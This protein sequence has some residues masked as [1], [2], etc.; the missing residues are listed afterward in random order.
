[1]RNTGCIS[2][3]AGPAERRGARSFKRLLAP[4]LA[5]VVLV[6]QAAVAEAACGKK[7]RVSH[8]DSECL[9]A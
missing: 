2:E 1:M 5:F 4:A 6:L 9:S 3:P 7:H 8:R